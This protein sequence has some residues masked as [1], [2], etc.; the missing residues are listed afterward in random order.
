M[1]W[2]RDPWILVG[3]VLGGVGIAIRIHNAFAYGINMGFD[4]AVNWMCVVGLL[5]A[6]A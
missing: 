2:L 4:A 5:V 1:R 6:W 3:L